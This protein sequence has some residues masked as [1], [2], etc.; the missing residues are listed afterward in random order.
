MLKRLLHN[1]MGKF[2][3]DIHGLHQPYTARTI[4]ERV[5]LTE[6]FQL[7]APV[8]THLVGI[9]DQVLIED[10]FDSGQSGGRGD[11]VPSKGRAVIAWGKKVRAW[12]R[13][14]RTNR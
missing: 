5:F 12:A 14:H 11:G 2:M 7:A 8:R 3:L 6:T 10:G 1:R 9:L 4:D 13:E